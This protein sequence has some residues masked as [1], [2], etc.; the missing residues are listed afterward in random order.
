MNR[1][2]R[3]AVSAFLLASSVFLLG[4]AGNVTP[5]QTGE[6]LPDLV[7]STGAH[8][9]FGAAAD[10]QRRER[11]KRDVRLRLQRAIT[12]GQAAALPAQ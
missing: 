5:V 6:F 9:P 7:L 2:S 4:A 12:L 11:C 8:V 3:S 10:A 1:I